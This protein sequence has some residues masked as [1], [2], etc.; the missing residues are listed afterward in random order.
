MK[1]TFFTRLIAGSLI[2]ATIFTACN[3]NNSIDELNN[4]PQQTT[5]SAK[6]IAV[7]DN[8]N[9]LNQELTVYYASDAA[10]NITEQFNSFTF[11]FAGN[12][13]SG[14]AQVWNDLLAKIGRWNMAN[15]SSINLS[16]PTDLFTQLAFLNR[17]WTIGVANRGF[18][19]FTAA[20]GDE[21]YFISKTQ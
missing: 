2:T 6:G 14:D 10:V 3:K 21:I 12:Y 19:V 1:T 11:K 18:I 7:I 20:D 17:E 4:S 16:Y 13:P 8:P 9:I 5:T 15:Q